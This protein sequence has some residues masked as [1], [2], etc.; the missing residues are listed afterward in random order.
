MDGSRGAKVPSW[1]G[2]GELEGEAG[3]WEGKTRPLD[4]VINDTAIILRCLSSV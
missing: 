2:C 4:T 3:M 1:E